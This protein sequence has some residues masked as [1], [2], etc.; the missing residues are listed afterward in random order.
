[1]KQVPGGRMLNGRAQA[2][3]ERIDIY[4][5]NDGATRRHTLR[6]YQNKIL[7]AAAVGG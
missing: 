5:A 6:Y 4:R 7:F 2:R 3:G 1:M